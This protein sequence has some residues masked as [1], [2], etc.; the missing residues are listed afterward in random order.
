MRASSANRGIMVPGSITDGM[1]FACRRNSSGPS[2]VPCG[3]PEVTLVRWDLMPSHRTCCWR[4]VRN[5]KSYIICILRVK[6]T[7]STLS[8]TINQKTNL[9]LSHQS[10]GVCDMGSGSSPTATFFRNTTLI[11][12]VNH[13]TKYWP[14]IGCYN[15]DLKGLEFQ[16]VGVLININIDMLLL[17]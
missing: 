1:S 6:R 3:T 11:Y 5:S 15:S 9:S 16:V 7:T 14:L 8:C 17:L 12:Y 2:T 13:V 4:L 10:S